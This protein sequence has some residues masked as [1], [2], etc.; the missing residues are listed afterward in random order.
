MQKIPQIVPQRLKVG[1]AVGGHPDADILTAFAERSLLEQERKNVLAHIAACAECREIV[2]LA[3]PATV[4]VEPA[5]LAVRRSWF[6]WPVFRWGFATAG[7]AL[8]TLGVVEFEQRKP[9]HSAVVARQVATEPVT[10]QLQDQASSPAIPSVPASSAPALT[11]ER[12]SGKVIA[13][14]NVLAKDKDH[15]VAKKETNQV[16]EGEFRR[17]INAQPQS[18]PAAAA[19]SASLATDQFAKKSPVPPA[20]SQM[21]AAQTVTVEVQGA[22]VAEAS[23]PNSFVDQSSGYNP[24]PLSRAKPAN[25]Q[26]VQAGTAGTMLA[27][28]RWSITAVGGLQR[29]LDQG[30]TWQDVNV[31]TAEAP[32][33]STSGATIGGAMKTAEPQNSIHGQALKVSVP[34]FFRSVAAAGNEVWAGGSNAALFHSVDA[35]GHWTRVAP[36]SAGAMLTGDVV[37][38]EFSDAQHGAVTTSTPEL[39]ITSDGGQTWQKR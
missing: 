30:K 12:E 32:V 29:S 23:V 19:S 17:L 36:S 20:A 3:L 37:S 22:P 2:S 28:P 13:K 5:S 27:T 39:W 6:A 38:V 26:V 34:V 33:A 7:V 8:I 4:G 16:A 10:T 21:A 11:R 14:D 15:V 1:A 35:G 18:A 25:I 24:A 9:E 31:D